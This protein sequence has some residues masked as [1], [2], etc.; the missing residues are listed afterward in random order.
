MVVGGEGSLK[1]MI[2]ADVG[3]QQLVG[4]APWGR[5]AG[6]HLVISG[7]DMGAAKEN[8]E[9]ARVVA[10]YRPPRPMSI[11]LRSNLPGDGDS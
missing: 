5:S 2:F 10:P 8:G 7:A 9:V 6:P 3:G 1:S 4:A 11:F